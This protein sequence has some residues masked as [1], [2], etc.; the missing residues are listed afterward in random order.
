MKPGAAESFAFISVDGCG[1]PKGKDRKLIRSHAMIGKNLR[2]GVRPVPAS[3]ETSN[4]TSLSRQTRRDVEQQARRKPHYTSV[5]GGFA[6][7]GEAEEVPAVGQP[8]ATPSDLR[9]VAFAGELDEASRMILYNCET[10]ASS[11]TDMRDTRRLT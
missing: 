10:C 1:K 4:K 7:D 2:I 9:L 3:N 6:A 8:A 11:C 5:S